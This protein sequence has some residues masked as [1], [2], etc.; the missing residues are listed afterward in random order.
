MRHFSEL[1]PDFV[2]WDGIQVHW[3]ATAKC[4]VAKFKSAHIYMALKWGRIFGVLN[5]ADENRLRYCEERRNDIWKYLPKPE[6]PP[7]NLNVA[8]DGLDS[9]DD[10]GGE[11]PETSPRVRP[12]T[13]AAPV[14]KKK[15]QKR[16]QSNPRVISP[17]SSKRTRHVNTLD[18]S[19]SY[20]CDALMM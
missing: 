3:K 14:T 11:R 15:S 10:Y 1:E 8:G 13:N 20:E 18:L 6:A 17:P 12:R 16:K 2:T 5:Q 19:T 4:A 9:D 7:L